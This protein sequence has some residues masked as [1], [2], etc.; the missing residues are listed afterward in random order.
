[1]KHFF[2]YQK[3]MKCENFSVIISTYISY[4]GRSLFETRPGFKFYG[5]VLIVFVASPRGNN[6]VHNEEVLWG[7]RSGFDPRQGQRI[8]LLAPASRPVLGPTRPPVQWVPGVLSRGVKRGRG[9]TL[10]THPH[11]VPRSRMS[12]SYASPSPKRFYGVERDS[13]TLQ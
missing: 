13:F 11:L 7:G 10:T 8:F 4:S 2:T 9:V 5:H 12:R 6:E 1:M 3:Y